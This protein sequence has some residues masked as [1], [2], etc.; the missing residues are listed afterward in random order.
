MNSDKIGGSVDL[1]LQEISGNSLEDFA[2]KY[3]HPFLVLE[4]E[5]QGAD[6]E[7]HTTSKGCIVNV[8]ERKVDKQIHPVVERPD[9]SPFA[10]LSIGRSSQNHIVIRHNL[11]SKV[12]LIIDMEGDDFVIRDAGSR[13]GSTLNNEPLL[14][15]VRK[16][17]Q[18]GDTITL[19]DRIIVRFFSPTSAYRWLES[20]RSKG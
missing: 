13:N 10:F 14:V 2:S 11:V 18:D 15:K 1:L 6:D 7:G 4:G 9:S 5:I 8:I 19:A 17:L 3:P 16:K 20:Q 12:H